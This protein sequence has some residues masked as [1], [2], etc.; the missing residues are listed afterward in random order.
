MYH[1]AIHVFASFL[2]F[3]KDK[4]SKDREGHTLLLPLATTLTPGVVGKG[5]GGKRIKVLGGGAGVVSS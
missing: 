3:E 5:K 1:G 4:R 2:Y